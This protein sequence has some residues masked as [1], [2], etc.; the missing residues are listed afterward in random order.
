[1]VRAQGQSRVVE[2]TGLLRDPLRLAAHLDDQRLGGQPQ[3]LGGGD[4]EGAAR[5][6]LDVDGGAGERHRRVERE[7]QGPG[8]QRGVQ[9]PGPVPPGG[10]DEELPR[11]YGTGLREPLHQPRQ[12]VVGDGQQHQLG[13]GQHLGGRHDGHIG[14]Q[15]GRA[16]PGGVGDPGDGH[17]AV[18]G[19]LERGG[20]CGTDAARSHDADGEAGGAVPRV[21]GFLRN[22]RIHAA[23]AF[24]SSPRRVPDDFSACYASVSTEHARRPQPVDN[25]A[26]VRRNGRR[27]TR[28]CRAGPGG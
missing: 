1:M 18:T 22:C 6:P 21:E 13:A 27:N 7:R 28:A 3:L 12:R 2:R 26:G 25:S 17:R 15:S 19:E 4:P 8:P 24:R 20:E 23:M 9:D 16:A 10:V 14:E 5:E 11:P